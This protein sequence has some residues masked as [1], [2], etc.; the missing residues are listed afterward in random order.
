MQRNDAGCR[1][2][3]SLNQQTIGRE[4]QKGNI[5][6]IIRCMDCT[7]T[8]ILE[9]YAQVSPRY[10][11]MAE[12][13]LDDTQKWLQRG[14]KE[15]AY[16]QF[17]ELFL[18][19]RGLKPSKGVSPSLLDV[20]CGIGGWLE[21][22]GSHFTCYGFDASAAQTHYAAKKFPNVRCATSF[23]SY[24]DQFNDWLP[25]FDLI[26]LWDVLEHI[27]TPVKFASELSGALSADGLFF[28]SVPAATPM[29]IKNQLLSIGWPRSK[30]SWNPSE[31]VSYYSPKTLRLLCEKT[32]LKVLKIGG[33]AV[34]P[35]TLSLFEL[36][37]RLAFKITKP[38]PS[39]SPQIFVLAKRKDPSQATSK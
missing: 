29:V 3:G 30:F 23:S 15:K 14:H 35:R 37:R 22:C 4:I 9:T 25:A 1:L 11:G 5:Y 27:G 2:C 36:A 38:F 32:N 21:F 28:A 12:E 16:G 7:L 31:H 20:G 26:T 17:L 10:A 34:Y 13:D 8:Y 19:L 6:S 18:C 33:V 24:Q 39:I